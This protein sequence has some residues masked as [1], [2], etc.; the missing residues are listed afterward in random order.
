MAII[1][2]PRY[3]Q[4]TQADEGK[5]NSMSSAGYIFRNWRSRIG[6]HSMPDSTVDSAAESYVIAMEAVSSHPI[7]DLT[8]PLKFPINP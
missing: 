3:E 4:K 1:I 2:K 7:C 5:F 8:T 6:A